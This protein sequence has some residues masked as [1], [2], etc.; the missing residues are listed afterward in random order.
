[1]NA[2]SHFKYKI[3]EKGN[4]KQWFLNPKE[5][6]ECAFFEPNNITYID[7]IKEHYTIE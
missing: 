7:F 6:R 3:D 1:M 4:P 2:P 5:I